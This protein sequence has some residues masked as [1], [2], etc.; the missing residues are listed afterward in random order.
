MVPVVNCVHSMMYLGIKWNTCTSFFLSTFYIVRELSVR[1]AGAV[2]RQSALHKENSG[3]AA[4]TLG[5]HIST[6]RGYQILF[7]IR[8]PYIN[9]FTN[10]FSIHSQPSYPQKVVFIHSITARFCLR[11]Y[12]FAIW[13]SFSKICHVSSRKLRK[14]LQQVEQ[15][16]VVW[17][18]NLGLIHTKSV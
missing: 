7:S 13:L 17:Q 12:H 8:N 3:F 9:H 10:H 15:K 6:F 14:R 1:L 11:P 16:A 2:G 4:P 5:L 18:R